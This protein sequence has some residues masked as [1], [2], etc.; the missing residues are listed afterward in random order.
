MTTKEN[1]LYFFTNTCDKK[2]I[3]PNLILST[4]G[5]PPT[6]IYCNTDI[7]NTKRNYENKYQVSTYNELIHKINTRLNNKYSLSKVKWV[8]KVQSV[9]NNCGF[10]PLTNGTLMADYTALINELRFTIDRKAEWYAHKYKNTRL[11]FQDFE[12]ELYDITYKAIE[13]YEQ[14]ND[15]DTEFT[16][17]ETLEL[18][19][20]NRMNSY[21]KSCL[22][23]VKNGQWNTAL[24][25]TDNFN[26]AEP[27]T[28]P[29]PEQQYINKETVT[30]MF[31]D[32]DLTDKERQL[33][34]IIYDYPSGSLREW[35][36]ELGITHPQTVKRLFQSLQKKLAYLK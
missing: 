17:I 8:W 36:T 29:S 24:P 2:E 31:N 4:P 18:Y 11:S 32:T 1:N 19:W 33:L 30:A 12:S 34:S 5:V 21:I 26:E 15:I 13:Y 10:E 6:D 23:T 35:G 27:D 14:S 25:L 7:S 3:I 16:L 22:Y 28:A 20:K 9:F